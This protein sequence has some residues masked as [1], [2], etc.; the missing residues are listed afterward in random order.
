MISGTLF[1]I[2]F[3]ASFLLRGELALLLF[4]VRIYTSRAPYLYK[5]PRLRLFDY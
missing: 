5:S 3:I 2:S 1:S 4:F